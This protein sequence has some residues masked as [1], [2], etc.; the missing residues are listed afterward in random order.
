MVDS[1]LDLNKIAF[2]FVVARMAYEVLQRAVVGEHEKPLGISI[3]TACR[4]NIALFD[5]RG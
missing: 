2:D 5:E 4:V 1:A 3:E